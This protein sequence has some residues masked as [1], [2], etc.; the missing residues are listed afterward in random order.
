MDDKTMVR[1]SRGLSRHLRHE[2]G[3]IGLGGWVQ[4]EAV[5]A[6]FTLHGRGRSRPELAEAV[7]RKSKQRFSFDETGCG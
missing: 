1:L 5:L 6:V 2:P 3:A 7:A 4:V